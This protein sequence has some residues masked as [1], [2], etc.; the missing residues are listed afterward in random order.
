MVTKRKIVKNRKV[1]ILVW[2]IETIPIKAYLWGIWNQNVLVDNII[3]DFALS[4]VSWSWVGE[5]KVHTVSLLDDLK[6]FKKNPYD[7][8]VVVK[9]VHKVLQE[10]DVVVAHNGDRFDTKKFN[11]K[12]FLLGLDPLPK[13]PS[14]DTL[15]V[16]K[17]HFSFTSNKLDYI[18]KS[19][20]FGGKDNI[21]MADF[22]GIAEGDVNSLKKMVRYNRKDVK[23]LKSVYLRIRGWIDNHPNLNMILNSTVSICPNCGSTDLRHKGYR[24]TQAGRYQR[25]QCQSCGANPSSGTIDRAVSSPPVR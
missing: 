10:A 15:K 11:T 16:A 12:A 7:D 24:Y 6:A 22:R 4:C 14:V 25:Y 2:D 17:K 18:A 5:N 20:G 21:T 23:I 1:K 3:E 19:L 13:I 8:S 9:A